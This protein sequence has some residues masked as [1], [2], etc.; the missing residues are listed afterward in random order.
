MSDHIPIPEDRVLDAVRPS[1]A[2]VRAHDP[3]A[4]PPV[5]RRFLRLNFAT[6]K[7]T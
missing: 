6:A 2:A 5:K 7:S 1:M 4:I 3:E